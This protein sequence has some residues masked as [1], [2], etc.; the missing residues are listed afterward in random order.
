MKRTSNSR[1]YSEVWN[2]FKI[3]RNDSSKCIC[4]ICSKHISR[5]KCVSNYSTTSMLK[6]VR[7][8]HKID[9]QQFSPSTNKH[10]ITY[11]SPTAEEAIETPEKRCH[12]DTSHTATHKITKLICEMIAIDFLPISM[13]EN[14]GFRRLLNE[15]QPSYVVPSDKYIT[16]TILPDIYS[17]VKQKVQHS[18][19][20]AAGPVSATL[21]IWSS[22]E[23]NTYLCITAHMIVWSRGSLEHASYILACK[24][25]NTS[26]THNRICQEVA[27]HEKDWNTKFYFIVSDDSPQIVNALKDFTQVADTVSSR[28]ASQA[29]KLASN[30]SYQTAPHEVGRDGPAPVENIVN[31]RA[32]PGSAPAYSAPQPQQPPAPVV[33]QPPPPVQAKSPTTTPKYV[34]VY[35]YVAADD[36]EVSIQEGDN[37]VD[38][39]VIDEGW[40]E[41]RVARTGAYG[42]FP[43]NYVQKV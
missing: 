31:R 13:V 21:N 14:E 23:N 12:F 39:T 9:L 19:K 15:L 37:M 5:G 1:K 32:P 2:Y 27:W 24:E 34:A 16:R 30:I 7:F 33:A 8:I 18:L 20:N 26:I 41:G 22:P 42:M 25:F 6:H 10:S 29:S 3:S 38:V 4:S 40:M 11:T 35:D 17:S 43:S 36:D 28:T